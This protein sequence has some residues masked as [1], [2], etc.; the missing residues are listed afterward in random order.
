MKTRIIVLLSVYIFILGLSSCNNENSENKE[1]ILTVASEK[2]IP[3]G[4]ENFRPLYAKAQ[5]V[6]R[7]SSWEGI[8]GF[9]HEDGYEYV[10]KVWRE[11]WHN[12]EVMDASMYRYKLLRVISK[13]KRD[14]RDLPQ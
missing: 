10:L 3:N 5:G 12:G 9:T 2:P 13:M 1:M 14:S 4:M 6:E 7:W 8:E 11:K